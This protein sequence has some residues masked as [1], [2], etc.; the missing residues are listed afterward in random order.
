MSPHCRVYFAVLPGFLALFLLGA[1]AAAQTPD[2][3]PYTTKK[4]DVKRLEDGKLLEFEDVDFGEYFGDDAVDAGKSSLVLMLVEA[5][6][7]TAWSVLT[8]FANQDKFMPHMELS[9]VRS[10][11]EGSGVAHVCFTYDVLWI[12]STNCFFIRPDEKAGTVAGYLDLENGDD[13][14]EG[15]NYFWHVRPWGDGQILMAYYQK[16]KYSGAFT[17]FGHHAFVGPKN[18]AKAIRKEV[19]SRAAK[20]KSEDE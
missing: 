8:D 13:R 20:G 4:D 9:E 19:E 18:T 14:L 2:L 5:P 12:E 1:A 17:A 15:V 10:Q 11:D 7:K 3:A 16:I 6:A